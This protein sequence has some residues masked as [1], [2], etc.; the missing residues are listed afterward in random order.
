M[1]RW[2]ATL[3][4]V[5]AI[6]LTVASA[7][8]SLA[9]APRYSYFARPP[10]GTPRAIGDLHRAVA[11]TLDASSFVVRLDAF[12]VDYVAPDR[13][14][15]RTLNSA[16]IAI[17]R[18][19][20]VGIRRVGVP[21]HWSV[22]RLPDSFVPFGAAQ[23]RQPLYQLL[24]ANSVVR[25]GE[26]FDVRRVVPAGDVVGFGAGQALIE[27]RVTVDRGRVVRVSSRAY[28][29][30]H[31]GSNRAGYR[32]SGGLTTVVRFVDEAFSQFGRVAD[33]V[34][35]AGRDV[36]PATACVFRLGSPEVCSRPS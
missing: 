24:R 11:R 33:I 18:T 7:A 5:A 6:A 14:E 29:L 17:G 19:V 36:G 10:R 20:Y 35:P 1:R 23:V 8:A 31:G 26:S 22:A 21:I 25:R 13:T 4:V 15:F 12:V 30:F 28:G 27:S 2:G 16:Q 32:T 9:T 34:A 3:V